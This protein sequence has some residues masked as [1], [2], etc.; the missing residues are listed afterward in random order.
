MWSGLLLPFRASLRNG[1]PTLPHT[2]FPKKAKTR[3]WAQ[4]FTAVAPQQFF[5][6]SLVSNFSRGTWCQK[7]I[8]HRLP[9]H[10]SV[11]DHGV[12]LSGLENSCAEKVWGF[13]N[14]KKEV[15]AHHYQLFHLMGPTVSSC[16]WT[17]GTAAE[18]GPWAGRSPEVRTATQI[19]LALP[20]TLPRL[21]PSP[22]FVPSGRE[23]SLDHG[24]H[25]KKRFIT[26]SQLHFKR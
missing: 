13:F 26:T 4:L 6:R 1:R 19:W 23:S 3:G 21:L 12:S 16:A 10:G 15:R 18:Q 14:K 2:S 9:V 17:W 7:V 8:Y 25:E 5:P 24:G 20:T 22:G 11:T